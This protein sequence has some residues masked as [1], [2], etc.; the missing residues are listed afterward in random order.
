VKKRELAE[1]IENVSD[2]FQE[3]RFHYRV[4]R[5]ARAALLKPALPRLKNLEKGLYYR[6]TPSA[7]AAMLEPALLHL[8]D[9]SSELKKG[10]ITEDFLKKSV[11]RILDNAT[12]HAAG[13]KIDKKAIEKSLKGH[14]PYLFWC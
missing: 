6:I 12:K 8:D 9:V 5:S 13:G 4:T 10:N 7:R 2:R 3:R 1:L 14:C 11:R